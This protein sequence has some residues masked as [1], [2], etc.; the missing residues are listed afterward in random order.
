[1]ILIDAN[2]LVY[3][4]VSSFAQHNLARDWL[5]QQLNAS[6]SVGLP[7]PSVLAFLRL[8]TN[9]RVF[10]HP[11]PIHDA[12]QQALSAV[13]RHSRHQTAARR[14]VMIGAE[15]RISLSIAQSRISGELC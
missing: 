9:P 2:I 12:W 14:I 5:D 7:W 10:E 13:S 4:H 8:V 3:A 6:T 11:E 1:M 15:E